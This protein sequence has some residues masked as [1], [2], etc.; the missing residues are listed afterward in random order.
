MQKLSRREFAKRAAFTGA[1]FGGVPVHLFG[2]RGPSYAEQ[3][4]DML[5]SYLSGK[6][7]TL[8]G[9]WDRERDALRTAAQLESRNRFV[10]EKF[11]EM[12]HGWPDKT[13][14][15]PIVVRTNERNGYRVE[16]VMF[17][18]RPNFWV[19]GNLYV[20]S[21]KG[22]FPG[23]ISPCGHYPLARMEPEYQFAY[24]NLVL[25][26]FV[27]LAFDP[28]GQGERRQYWN[29]QTGE[30]EVASA[31]TY[32][33][34]MP[35]QV[36]LLMGEDLTHYRIWD[37]M[38][39]IDY[40]LTRPE[41]DKEKIGC[42]GHSGGATLTI[43]ISSLDERV[44]CVAV[45]QG[46]T[47]HR[48][49]I[50]ASPGSRLGPS[51]VEQNIFPAAVHGID[52]CDLLTAIAPRPLLLTIENYSPAFRRTADHV[53]A[54]YAQFDTA[55]RFGTEEANDPHSWTVKL[56]QS[57]TDWFS[58]WFSGRRGPDREPD[59]APE[60]PET[61]YCTPNG[62]VRYSQQGETIFS[63]ILKNG[64]TVTPSRKVPA[65]AAELGEF[66]NR[67]A[68]EIRELIRYRAPEGPLGARHIV[69]TPRKGYKVENV[70]FLT[71]PG[72]HIPAW[73]FVPEKRNAE[74]PTVF[75]HEAGKEVEGQEFGLLEGLAREGHQVIA[76]DVRGIG[77]TT[78]P[79]S[80]GDRSGPFSHLFSVETAM[81]YLSWYMDEDLFGMRVR[82][83]VR[84]V[85]YALSRPDTGAASVRLVGKGAGALWALYAA[86]L[87]PR[88]ETVVAHG[89]LVSY[90]SLTRVDRYRQTAG[91]FV[92]DV[93]KHFDLPYVAAAIA[94]RR[95][96]LSSTVDPMNER[97]DPA[98]VR[99][100][101]DWTAAAYRNAGAVDRFQ[102]TES[103]EL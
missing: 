74:P 43:F 62:S 34:S 29:P 58:R 55:E 64:V 84:S 65:S 94:D 103:Y 26:G 99:Q 98:A 38:R 14:L 44:R 31:S 20:P 88:V 80:P 63:L 19:T 42:A 9:K 100:A 72:I 77:E 53:K 85:E 101:Y 76:V 97:L 35:G 3:H 10:R 48:W 57:T 6:L 71:E 7:N 30:T 2:E 16:N 96:I 5:V 90:A 91:V 68:G 51:D 59:L 75:V 39:A 81:A 61:L 69:T 67:L 1:V 49:P 79:H 92:R 21:G 37:G 17:Q 8:A 4:P 18:S 93:L 83:V 87:D 28:V 25:N 32:E 13:P 89:G 24:M 52:V 86:A 102:I 46:G 11:R 40:L 70:E 45:N 54:R 82:D 22:P 36:L 41:V 78:P 50:K 12:V 95:L 60:N 73:V 23:I 56:R 15:A 47:G 27:V 66:R 33:H